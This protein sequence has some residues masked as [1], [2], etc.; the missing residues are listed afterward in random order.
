MG[1]GRL[2]IPQLRLSLDRPS[3]EKLGGIRRNKIPGVY[4][5]SGSMTRTV[6]SSKKALLTGIR[7]GATRRPEAQTE[8]KDP[9]L[10]AL[11]MTHSARND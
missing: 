2:E 3:P 5:R 11:I 1:I 7:A 9:I 6:V 10:H 4:E 8:K